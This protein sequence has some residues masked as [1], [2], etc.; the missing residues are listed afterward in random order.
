MMINIAICLSYMSNDYLLMIIAILFYVLSKRSEH[1]HLIILLLFAMVYKSLLKEMLQIPAPTTSPT[2]YGFPSGHINFAVIFFGWFMIIYRTKFLYWFCPTVLALASLS[3]IYLGYHTY[4][5][6]IL[7]P[8]LPICF[9][10][11]YYLFMRHFNL[12]KF[13]TIFVVLSLLCQSLS[14]FFL[15]KMPIDIIIGSYGILGLGIG[16][17]MLQRKCRMF[18]FLGINSLIFFVYAGNLDKFIQNCTWLMVFG[19]LP[20][21]GKIIA[22]AR[23]EFEFHEK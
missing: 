3:T 18:V 15:D 9:L 20:M 11:L 16:I 8:L 7:T 21:I 19:V 6:V 14:K 13:I 4:S 12:D 23:T 10:I 1:A 5:D 2:K 22:L 17:F